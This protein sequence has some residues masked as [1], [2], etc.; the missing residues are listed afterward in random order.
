VKKKQMMDSEEIPQHNNPSTP[1]VSSMNLGDRRQSLRIAPRTYSGNSSTSWREYLSHF[2]RVSRINIWGDEQKL[3]YLWAHL[4]DAALSYVETLSPENT[5]TYA[6]ICECLEERFGD[7]QLAEVFKS[8][9]RSR[10]RRTD[11]SMPALA[12]DI[13][14]LVQRA[15]PELQHHA[16]EGLAIERFREALTDQEQ[17]MAV[18]RSKAKTLNQ[19]VQAAIDAESWQ[20]SENR[21]TSTPRVRAAWSEESPAQRIGK[22][23]LDPLEDHHQKQVESLAREV[24]ELK[25]KLAARNTRSVRKNSSQGSPCYYCNKEGH[26]IRD[27]Y[28]RLQDERNQ[29]NE[30][31][32]H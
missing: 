10:R 28:K 15:Y 24:G 32:Q 27:C 13:N 25:E 2:E 21:R 7:A 20:I 12:Q 18:F 30:Q 17:R 31:E 8:E 4:T 9:L 23:A 11:E 19:A 22:T 5:E 1:Y 14:R 6:G 16:I 29:G 3:D 26:F